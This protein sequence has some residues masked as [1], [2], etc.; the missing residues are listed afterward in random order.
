[1][2]LRLSAVVAGFFF[3]ASAATAQSI[4][5]GPSHSDAA[6]G[7]IAFSIAV[8]DPVTGPATLSITY[9]GDL[10]TASE[11]VTVYFDGV[12]VAVLNGG[13]QCGPDVTETFTVPETVFA[14]AAADG[15]ISV[16][17]DAQDDQPGIDGVD[18]FCNASP[19]Y[20][21]VFNFGDG[22]SIAA[23][24]TLSYTAAAETAPPPGDSASEEDLIATRAA[25]IQTSGLDAARRVDR[26][27]DRTA[28]INGALSFEGVTISSGPAILDVDRG[29]VGFAAGFDIGRTM[30]WTEGR[31]MS[32]NDDISDEGRF[33]IF[34]VGADYLIADDLMVGIAAQID[35]I[36]Q[37]D[38]ASGEAVN[39]TGWM[40]GPVAT[41]ALTETLFV[42]A[43]VAFGSAQN[44]VDRGATTDRFDS[45]RALG[46]V[47]LIG[48]VE[49][50]DWTLY[51]ELELSYFAERS[52]SYTSATLGP[53]DG[54]A[55]SLGQARLGGTLER[56]FS[57]GAG[58][59]VTGYLEAYAL[60]SHRFEGAVSIG[61]F[62]AETE[63]WTGEVEIGAIYDTRSGAEIRISL[64]RGGFFSDAENIWASLGVQIP[65]Q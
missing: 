51:P 10:N 2:R 65:L 27:R 17:L 5:F 11:F 35:L 38:V 22:V 16:L 62:V 37:E 53:I 9:F 40:I 8:P 61:S 36:E 25:L 32:F 33:G 3:Y 26:L 42:D 1:M 64:G 63:G 24:G 47:S 12:S 55:F 14:T 6:G 48:F 18:D 54:R 44:T 39:G 23:R 46:E 49:R 15:Q 56:R 52:S 30:V 19:P 4:D 50:G 7:T 13:Q 59:H 41:A 58:D 21:T 29:V 31:I 45:N 28:E 60:Y 57:L 34:H 43:R 20:S